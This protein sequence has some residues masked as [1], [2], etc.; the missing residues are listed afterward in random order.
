[1]KLRDDIDI[2]NTWVTADS[3][4]GHDNI[5]G[6]CHRPEDH[7]QVMIA[8]WRKEVPDDATV[9]HLGDLSYKGNARFKNLMAPELTGERKLLVLG[10]HD[11]SPYKFYRDCGFKVVR[12]FGIEYG[13]FKTAV[14]WPA[15]GEATRPYVV[16]F[17]HYPWNER[18]DGVQPEGHIRVH[19]HIHNNGY[20][21]DEFVPLLRN[22]INVGVELTKYKPVN[23]GRLLAAYVY[24]VYPETTQ[25]QLAEARARKAASRG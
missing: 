3:H 6:F 15:P 14:T 1:M 19:G 23:L 22:H 20:S 16:S 13:E 4:F 17:N 9:L 24:G 8:E 25:E 11:R 7:E 21:R 18:D 10:N 2:H 12:P 5:V